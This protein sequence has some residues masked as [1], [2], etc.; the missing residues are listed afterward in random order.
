MRLILGRAAV[1]IE[2]WVEPLRLSGPISR[3]GSM[4]PREVVTPDGLLTFRRIGEVPSRHYF[5]CRS[6]IIAGQVPCGSESCC[7]LGAGP[8]LAFAAAPLGLAVLGPVHAGDI[9]AIL[10][11]V[12]LAGHSHK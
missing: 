4:R 10:A 11:H 8:S 5:A 2:H 6:P 1:A 12:D 9:P 7:R 3:R